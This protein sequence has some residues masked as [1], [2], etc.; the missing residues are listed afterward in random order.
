[1]PLHAAD[2]DLGY[3]QSSAPEV[4]FVDPITGIGR[5]RSPGAAR[6]KHSIATH[7]RDEVEIIV[8][9]ITKLTL[10]PLKGKNVT[11]TEVFSVP[12]IL[13]G[14]H[15]IVKENN[16]LS[17]GLGGCRT[18][19]S[20]TLSHYPIICTVQ[21]TPLHSTVGIKDLFYAKPR[22]D[23]VTGMSNILFI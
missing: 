6:V 15:E 13:K 12:L 5:A 3:W 22:F 17:R 7:L 20:F 1:M 23:I 10:V 14:K 2:G 19:T 16:V 18:Q 9:P 8:N 21:F 11:G 4:L